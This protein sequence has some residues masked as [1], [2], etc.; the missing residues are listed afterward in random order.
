[1]LIPRHGVLLAARVAFVEPRGERREPC[2]LLL[3]PMRQLVPCG[4][5]RDLVEDLLPID[6]DRVLRG[7]V[8]AGGLCDGLREAW[9]VVEDRLKSADVRGRRRED[10]QART[11]VEGATVV[12]AH[13][14]DVGIDLCGDR[15]RRGA[16]DAQLRVDLGCTRPVELEDDAADRHPRTLG[17][18]DRGARAEIPERG[19]DV[20][21]AR[22]GLGRGEHARGADRPESGRHDRPGDREVHRV[23]E[24]VEHHGG[25]RHPRSG[26]DAR[27]RRSDAQHRRKWRRADR[28]LEALVGHRAVG[29]EER[30]LRDDRR[31]AP[32]LRVEDHGVLGVV[33]E[34]GDRPR[35][36]PHSEPVR[37]TA[38]RLA[39]GERAVSEAVPAQRRCG[40]ARGLHHDGRRPA[41][42]AAERAGHIRQ[43]RA[44]PRCG[45][46]DEPERGRGARRDREHSELPARHDEAPVAFGEAIRRSTRR[47][48]GLAVGEEARVERPG[49]GRL[50]RRGRADP[51]GRDARALEE[52]ARGHVTSLA[53]AFWMTTWVVRPTASA[54]RCT[55]GT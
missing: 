21:H 4:G 37:Q 26:E 28:G 11:R 18:R 13:L 6:R 17:D 27:L 51:Y 23:V 30:E 36:D 3:H 55:D 42:R 34:T 9:V 16:G 29:N 1:M 54:F 14:R 44:V 52:Q 35:I 25:R 10:V 20:R 43:V 31:S 22:G 53:P 19:G 12:G 47:T 45:G 15:R 7:R 2:D 39:R 33:R 24:L 50:Q 40:R 46:P 32:V 41:I 5:Q 48:G 49:R 8:D 38:Q